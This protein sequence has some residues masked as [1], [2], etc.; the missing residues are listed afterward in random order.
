MNIVRSIA[1]TVAF[2]GLF[3]GAVAAQSGPPVKPSEN[4]ALRYW[5]AFAEMQDSGMITHPIPSLDD[6]TVKELFKE[7]QAALDT[8]YRGT[9]LPD[10]DWGIEY[11]L[12]TDA[13]VEY[14]RKALLLGRLNATYVMYLDKQ[15]DTEGAVRALVAGLRFS[16]DVAN[17]GT[18][19]ATDVA[20]GLLMDHLPMIPN[21]VQAGVSSA[22]RLALQRAV[23]QLGPAGLDWEGAIKRELGIYHGTDHGLST[24]GLAALAQITPLYVGA[25]SD[26][27]VLPRLQGMIANAPLDLRKIMPKPQPVVEAKESLENHLAEA[28]GLLQ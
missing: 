20:A 16:H 1:A 27:A 22:Q 14:V 23:A 28:R 12:G 4:A 17:G 9:M 26:P 3:V 8:M 18:L 10:C 19:L 11:Q 7:N 2:A 13:P 24:Q 15:G 25:M 5:S 21:V 6:P